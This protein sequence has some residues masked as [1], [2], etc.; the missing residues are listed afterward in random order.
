MAATPVAAPDPLGTLD[1]LRGFA[2][3][4]ILAMNIRLMAGPFGAYMYPYG[5]FDFT[6]ANRAVSRIRSPRRG[7]ESDD[8]SF[9]CLH[10]PRL[11]GPTVFPTLSLF[12]PRRC[13]SYLSY[14]FDPRLTPESPC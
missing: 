9:C 14:P 10:R 7:P 13:P 2:L 1:V 11:I 12:V 3:L 5:L 6:G 8:V 4:A